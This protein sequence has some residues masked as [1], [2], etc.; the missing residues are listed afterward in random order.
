M[1]DH[2]DEVGIFGPAIDVGTPPAR[3]AQ[4]HDPAFDDADN[5]D[6]AYE[7]DAK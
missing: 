7:D 6:R 3:I 1:T 2:L 4:W 5:L